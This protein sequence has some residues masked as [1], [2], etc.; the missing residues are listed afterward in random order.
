MVTGT[1]E[2]AEISNMCPLVALY[3]IR[4]DVVLLVNSA[5]ERGA[6]SV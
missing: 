5:G 2:T 4:L 1:A 6:S 3:A